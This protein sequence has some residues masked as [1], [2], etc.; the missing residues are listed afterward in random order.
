MCVA[1]GIISILL[2]L[3]GLARW[4]GLFASA[5]KALLPPVLVMGGLVAVVA[6]VTEIRD[7]EAGNQPK[8]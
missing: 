6:G 7:T 5:V 3:W 1:C 4:W 8:G 2:G